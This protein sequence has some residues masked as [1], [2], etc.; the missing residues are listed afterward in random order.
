MRRLLTLTCVLLAAAVNA[1]AVPPHVAVLEQ[2][3]FVESNPAANPDDWLLAHVDVETTGL[4][5]GYN[6]MID[7]GIVMTDLDGKYVDQLF[8]RIMPEHLDRVAP[9][10]VAVNGF[11]QARWQRLSAVSGAE[12]VSQIFRFHEQA[13]GG[14]H[15]LFT[16]FNAWFD[17]S[18]VDH[19]FRQQNRSWRE[20]YH[21]FV[22]DLPSMAWSV[23]ITDLAGAGLA[24]KLAIEPETRDPLEHTGLTG[25]EAN[26]EVYRALLK[27]RDR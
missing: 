7:I 9:G 6:E 12:A 14:K 23:G 13:A 5:P 22:L 15:V 11:S 8:L 19:L 25:A 20:L 18:F 3:P 1:D 17:I 16:G 10:A 26:V 4:V 27:Y 24:E 2:I 21:Y